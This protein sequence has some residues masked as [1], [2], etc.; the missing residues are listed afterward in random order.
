MCHMALDLSFAIKCTL[1]IHN[2][3]AGAASFQPHHPASLQSLS[4]LSSPMSH[5][6]TY[7]RWKK[8][9]SHPQSLEWT[10]GEVC[11]ACELSVCGLCLSCLKVKQCYLCIIYVSILMVFCLK[12]TFAWTC[13]TI[14]TSEKT[15]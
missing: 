9:S 3:S 4:L 2:V 6:S 1:L 10:R 14:E 5:R 12:C 8:P 7:S 15:F 13:V 11:G